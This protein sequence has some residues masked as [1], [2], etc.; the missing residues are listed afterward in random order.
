VENEH[1]LFIYLFDSAIDGMGERTQII[2]F[3]VVL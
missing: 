2:S 1:N 3:C